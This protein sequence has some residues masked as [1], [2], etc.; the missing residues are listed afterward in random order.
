MIIYFRW[1]L[2]KIKKIDLFEITILMD[3]NHQTSQ[4]Q[5][6]ESGKGVV[7]EFGVRKIVGI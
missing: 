6:P 5:I 7:D 3:L 2:T 1:Q 4:V